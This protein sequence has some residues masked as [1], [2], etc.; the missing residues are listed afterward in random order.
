MKNKGLL[1]GV[2]GVLC[3]VAGFASAKLIDGIAE[4]PTNIF[5]DNANQKYTF[6]IEQLKDSISVVFPIRVEGEVDF[7]GQRVP[8]EDAEVAERLDRELQVNAYRHANTFSNMKL[9]NRHFGTLERILREEGVPDDFKFLALIESDFRDVVS[10]SGA[11]GFWQFMP[12]TARQY[13]LEVN[14]FIDERYHIEKATRA[15]CKYLKDAKLELGSWTMAA[16]A[17]NT[18]TNGMFNR[19]ADQHSYNYY[20]LYLNQETSRYVF[21]ILAMKIIFSNPKKAGYVFD[22]KDLYQP[23]KFNEVPVDTSIEDLAIF[24]KEQNLRY[25]DIKV[26][27]TWIRS[28]SIPNKGK[29]VYNIKILQ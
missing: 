17:Y 20:D 6:R 18:G 27:N 12:V 5:K 15:A 9:A 25:K 13:G 29:K 7:A 22:D 28:K 1:Y 14:E 3:L 26:L 16:A 8:L 23:L 10:P 11:A 4:K 24:A 21:R 19:A 2:I